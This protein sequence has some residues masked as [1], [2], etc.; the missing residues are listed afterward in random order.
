MR[1][2]LAKQPGPSTTDSV[3]L[4]PALISILLPHIANAQTG[5]S[6]SASSTVTVALTQR[7]RLLQ[8]E[9]DELYELLK[10]SE[11]GNLKDEVR[12]LRK[13]VA[14]L[15]AALKGLLLPSETRLLRVNGYY[16]MF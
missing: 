6:A 7:A 13:V 4:P 5:T 8:E 1:R 10:R 9:N 15:E 3:T 2:Y 11:T 16:H 14:K 12:G